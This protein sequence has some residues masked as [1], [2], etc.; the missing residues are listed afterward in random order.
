[1]NDERS[2][3][4]SIRDRLDDSI[5]TLDSDVSRRLRLARSRALDSYQEKHGYWKPAGGF[6]LATMLLVAI[7]VWQFGGNE[8]NIEKLN[9]NGIGIVQNMVDLEMIASSDSLQ[10]IEDLEF[11]QWLDSLEGNAG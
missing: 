11:Y 4:N 9:N 1:M 8:G 10:L 6:A 3:T 5:E 7:G 2:F